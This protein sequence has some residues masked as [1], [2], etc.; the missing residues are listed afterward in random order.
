MAPGFPTRCVAPSRA[1]QRTA[2]R[3]SWRHRGQ[4]ESPT[5]NVGQSTPAFVG[6]HARTVAGLDYWKIN[7]SNVIAGLAE[8]M[9]CEDY[10]RWGSANVIRRAADPALSELP[11]PI[12]SVIS[13]TKTSG[14]CVHGLRHRH[15]VARS[16][17]SIGRFTFGLNGTYI[18]TYKLNSNGVALVSG[19]GNNDFG[20]IPAGGTTRRSTGAGNLVGDARTELPERLQRMRRRSHSA[21]AT[22]TC[23]Q[24]QVWD[25]Q[26]Q[27]T[28]FKNAAITLGTKNL[29]G[30][31][32]PSRSMGRRNTPLASDVSMPI[33]AG[34]RTTRR[35]ASV[36]IERHDERRDLS[37]AQATRR[38]PEATWARAW[39]HGLGGAGFAIVVI[40]ALIDSVR[41][42][43]KYVVM[44]PFEDGIFKFSKSVFKTW[45]SGS[46]SCLAVVWGP[47]HATQ[48][49][50]R[51]TT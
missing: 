37:D 29:L 14:T 4:S 9:V 3:V 8:D 2:S 5:R 23:R 44:D 1:F 33:P 40:V 26:G 7:K 47:N 27:Y 25:V 10:A 28:G 17:T 41:Q 31:N 18:S 50:P 11:G 6:T 15:Q 43:I 38:R 34:A 12:E 49:G 30:S 22:S 21:A 20:P 24:L 16:A 39:F 19:V 45:R 51:A 13:G 42:I 36:S 35:S 46:R 32:P 48:R